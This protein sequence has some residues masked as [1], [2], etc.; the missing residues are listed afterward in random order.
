MKN[1]SIIYALP[2]LF[3]FFVMGFCDIVGFSSDYVQ[4][5][6]GWSDQMTGFVPS[7]VFIWFLFLG[8]PVGNF[9]NRIG[10]KSTV[11]TSMAITVIGSILP[12]IHFSS[13]SCMAAYA[14]L[15][16][17]NAILQV[18]LNPLLNNVIT[19]DKLL[20]SGLNAG[21]VIKALSSLAGPEIVLLAVSRFGEENWYMCFPILG[22]ITLLSAI[23]LLATP[24]PKEELSGKNADVSFSATLSLLKDKTILLLFIGILCIV[25][26]DVSTNFLSSKIMAARFSWALEDAKIAPQIYFICRTVGA[27]IGTVLLAKMSG[28][29]YFKWN[30]ILC[31][32]SLAILAIIQNPTIDLIGIGATGFF[33]SSIFSVIY[34][35]ALNAMPDNANR[36]SGLMITAVAGGGIIT[37]AVGMAMGIWGI[38]GGIAVTICCAAYLLVCAYKIR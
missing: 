10:R 7:L 32:V 28:T 19:N 29:T 38:A 30:M 34:A 20:T 4:K 36:I 9:M 11:L 16:I 27:L 14:M 15:G 13:M 21:Q 5:S 6:F 35:K 33:A 23:W 1:K 18:S 8:I 22:G 31:L 25:G 37:P 24:L 2:V 17:G 12:L 3:G 26:I